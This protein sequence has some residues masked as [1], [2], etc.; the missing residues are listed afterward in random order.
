MKA[1]HRV[2]VVLSC[3]VALLLAGCGGDG[4]GGP[5]ET[6][7]GIAATGAAIPNAAVV[8]K[9][10]TGASVSTTTNAQGQYS[11]NVGGMT[12]PFIGQVTIP[13]GGELFSIAT[14]TGTANIDTYSN[15]MADAFFAVRGTT[16]EAVFPTI[17]GSTDLP[18]DVEVQALEGIVERTIQ[19]WLVANEV[20][21]LAFDIVTT[22]YAANGEGYDRV[23]EITTITTPLPPP[24]VAVTQGVVGV[25]VAT[26][27][28]TDGPT[29]QDSVLTADTAGNLAME[30]TTTGPSGTSSTYDS[31]VIPP[32][33]AASDAEE[34]VA[35]ALQQFTNTVNTQGAALTDAHLQPY[36]TT[37]LLNSGEN[38]AIFTA[39]AATSLRGLTIDSFSITRINSYDEANDILDV[40]VELLLSQGAQTEREVFDLVFKRVG[41]AYLIFGDQ[42][43]A[44]V[45]ERSVQFETRTD[46]ISTGDTTNTSINVDVD[47]PVGTVT[48]ITVTGPGGFSDTPLVKD[49]LTR[50]E[51]L[52]PTPTTT[53]DYVTDTFYANSGAVTLP[54]PP[55]TYTFTLNLN[56]TGTAVYT[57]TVG[58]SAGET[59]SY[60]VSPATHSAAAVK[61]QTITI[62]WSLP[63]TY[64]VDEIDVSGQMTDGTTNLFIE[65]DQPVLA[66][67]TSATI[68]FTPPAGIPNP[69]S[70]NPVNFNLSFTGPNGERSQLIYM[71]DLP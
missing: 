70:F 69:A 48:S 53:L 27:N 40:E 62:S 2:G 33:A 59:I 17:T 15:L 66:T 4:D 34:G 11:V 52:E 47:A 43:V 51:V 67:A 7:S 18:N 32:T 28:I 68:T 19:S 29:T 58:G 42:R 6:L 46:S 55:A 49:V 56:P 36:T 13:A 10:S 63:Q 9:D 12:P 21:P 71:F 31:T 65:A 14:E 57:V 25:E 22:P 16:P 38:R 39:A 45:N 61:G 24:L 5:A 37:D 23:L 60:S 20:D 1:A 30:S 64:A 50:T 8:V 26:I 41:A 35:L 54:T 44:E 3:A